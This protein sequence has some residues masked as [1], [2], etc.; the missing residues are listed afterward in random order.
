MSYSAVAVARVPEGL[1]SP[2]RQTVRRGTQANLT[3][4]YQDDHID[5]Y[6]LDDEKVGFDGRVFVNTLVA[7]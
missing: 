2:W 6:S 1:A 7:C 4:C 3:N 5:H